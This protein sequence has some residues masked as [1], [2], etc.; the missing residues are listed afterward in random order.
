MLKRNYLAITLLLVISNAYAGKDPIAWSVFPASGFPAQSSTGSRYAVTYT[1]T[2]NLPFAV[3]LRIESAFVGGTFT[4]RNECNSQLAPK[5][6]AGDTC[7]VH[8]SFQPISARQNN[9]QLTLAY[10]K[11]RVPLTKLVSTSV[12]NETTDHISGHVTTPLPP[13]TYVGNAY[14]VAFTFINNGTAAVTATAVNISGF[15]ANTNTCTS[16][17]APNS[18]CNVTGS[19]T[20]STTGQTSLAVTYVYNNGS[21]PLVSQTNVYNNSGCHQVDG[22]AALPLPTNTFI[23]ADNVVRYDFTNYCATP[24]TLGT[25]SITSDAT[26]PPTLTK[27]SDTCSGATLIS[28]GKCSVFVSVIP[29]TTA[30]AANDLSITATVPYL[31]NTLTASTTTS[32][33]VNAIQNQST[34]HTMMF[35]NQCDQNVW[36]EFQNGAGGANSPDPTPANQR[37]ISDYQ[38]NQQVLGAA[39]ATKILTFDQ[40]INGAIY[41]R[42]GC[43][44]TGA[45]TTAN[46]PVT[47][48][49]NG[50]CQVGVGATGPLT[51]FE[52]FMSSTPASD[53]VYDVSVINGF[54]IPGEVRSMAATISPFNF[55]QACGQSAGA[56][57]QPSGSSLGACPW[58]FTPPSTVSPDTPANYYWVSAGTDDGCTSSCGTPG[59]VCGMAYASSPANTPINRRCG[60][61]QGYWTLASYIGFTSGGQWGSTDLYTSY[62]MGGGMPSTYGTGAIYANLYGCQETSNMSLLSGYSSTFNVC[63]CYNWNQAGSVAPTA[64]SFNCAVPSGQNPDWI[65]LVFPRITWL[66]QAC[67]TAYTYQYDDASTSFTCNVANQK[68]AYQITYCPAGKSGRPGT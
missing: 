65:S 60:T 58:S 68:T 49:G 19:F 43:D 7:Q 48:S 66:K 12:S 27:G 16:A 42:T 26:T 36:Y 28:G 67:P 2:N 39:P 31:N 55:N 62:N 13:A 64:Q 21:V 4:I 25:V 23:Y 57:I 59:Q 3:P 50:D 56:V 30:P 47:Q 54:N 10:D 5:K 22:I 17:L 52:A 32:E 14:P 44:A 29:N 35:V 18:T 45:C 11:N 34:L 46:C 38:L 20:P 24:E 40:Y 15:T 41:G 1:F 37:S 9:I 53:G 61:F 8:V 6:Q 63:G 51:I 33:V